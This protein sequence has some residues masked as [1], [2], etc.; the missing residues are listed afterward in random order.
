MRRWRWAL[1]LALALAL[2]L[3][4]WAATQATATP[5]QQLQ[6]W[7][8]PLKAQVAAQPLLAMGLYALLYTLVVALSLPLATVLTLG[9]GALFGHVL[10]SAL[11]LGSATLGACGALLLSRHG[12]RPWVTR[13]WGARWQALGLDQPATLRRALLSLR[14]AP[15]V[16]FVLLNLLMGLTRIRVWDFAWISALGMAPATVLYVHAGTELGQLQSM[17]DLRSPGLWWALLGLAIWPWLLQGLRV[18]LLPAWQARQRLRAALRP[19]RAQ[20]PRRFDTQLL[21]IGGGAAG[22][23]SAHMATSL[24]ARVTLVDDA[25]MGGECLHTGCVPSKTLLACARQ[26][27]AARA[28]QALQQGP[29]A[30]LAP[31]SLRALVARVD[32][33]IA[34]IA[35]HDSAE[36]YRALGAEVIQ[37]R[38]RLRTPWCVAIT[39]PDGQVIE[40]H[41]RAIVLATGARPVL[42]DVPGLAAVEPLTTE[43]F[44]ARL[45]TLAQRQD[46][47]PPRWLLLGGGPAGCELA[48]ALAQLGAQVTLVERAPRLLGREWPEASAAMAQAL[49]QAGV[50]LHVA[51]EVE[52]V[53]LQDGQRCAWL[54]PLQDGAAPRPP[55]VFDE[56]LCLTGRQPR[57]EDLGLEALGLSPQAA[58]DARLRL[59]LPHLWVAGDASGQAGHTHAAAAQAWRVSAQALLGGWVGRRAP[60]WLPRVVYTDPEIAS[61]GLTPEQALAQGVPHARTHLSLAQLDRAITEGRT[62]GWVEVLTRPGSDRLL[63]VCIVAPHAGEMLAEWTLAMQH[64]LGLGRLLATVHAYP[65]WSEAASRLAGQS[66]RERLPPWLLRGLRRWQAWRLRA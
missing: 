55:V 28:A 7:Q 57:R 51:H 5:L 42:P 65:T 17:D 45:R 47:L 43:T 48:Q 38:A 64:G 40:R 10:G 15:V 34:A 4:A 18:H 41:A 44:W 35:P 30:A 3:W 29:A 39:T 62:E 14:L 6:A 52:R 53:A 1:W 56:C 32:A 23:V 36:R 21:V 22:L 24:Q 59:G 54:R 12:L 63:G 50:Q 20:R 66:Q 25:Q 37:G 61:V 11:V 8:A 13:R 2:G 27:Q 26:L 9:A 60:V 31:P 46:H 16:P 33:A 19:W 49:A 58:P